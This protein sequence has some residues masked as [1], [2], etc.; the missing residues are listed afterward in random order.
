MLSTKLKNARASRGNV[1]FMILIAIALIAGLTYAITRTENGG[2][3]MSRE[4]ADLA[5][6]QL[7]G[8]ALNLKRAAENITR[9]GY[10]ETQISF[11]SDQLTGYGTPD[12][13]PRAEVF[14]IA[15]G[16]VSYMPPPANVSDGSQWEFTGSTAA[17]GV[18]DDATPDLMVVFPHISE[19]V[20]RAYNKKAGYDPA[21]SI[22]TDSGEC[23][24]NT[25]KRFDGTFPSSG[26]NTMDANT[27]RVPAPFACVQCGNDY[28]AYYVLL[29]R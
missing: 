15:G 20:C 22:P 23:V 5:A 2:D 3:A 16:G 14:N 4:R 17:P 18:G 13:N 26:A 11:A 19:A 10:S 28:N 24:Y 9:A 25:A 29:E 7:A 21:G 27:F 12:S 6:D 1:L 8:F